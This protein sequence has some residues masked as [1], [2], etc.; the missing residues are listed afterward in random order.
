[1]LSSQRVTEVYLRL[2]A[3]S[4]LN[5]PWSASCETLSVRSSFEDWMLLLRIE[6][7]WN[8]RSASM[9]LPTGNARRGGNASTIISPKTAPSLRF[10]S[11]L[12]RQSRSKFKAVSPGQPRLLHLNLY[13]LAAKISLLEIDYLRDRD[14]RRTAS[15]SAGL[16]NYHLPVLSG[17][18][19]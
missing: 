19:R 9:T 16:A 6:L 4:S 10:L 14:E 11:L 1:M 15:E 8:R 2:S 17:V 7:I 12:P 13:E 3:T 5:L 18:P